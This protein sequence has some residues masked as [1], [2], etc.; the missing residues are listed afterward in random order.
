MTEGLLE[1]LAPYLP[2]LVLERHASRAVPLAA[3]SEEQFPSAVVLVDVSGFTRLA[4]RL[5]QVGPEGA[6]QLTRILNA[7]FGPLID[8]IHEHGGDVA[9]F[10]GDA[11][12]VLW[13]ALDGNLEDAALAGV[14]CALALQTVMADLAERGTTGG[15]DPLAIKVVVGAGDMRLAH[16]GGT[17]NRWEVM[18]TGLPLVQIGQVSHDARPGKVLLTPD[19][20]ALVGDR[21]ELTPERFVN[22]VRGRTS[23]GAPD[24][25]NGAARQ[26]SAGQDAGKEGSRRDARALSGRPRGAEVATAEVDLAGT[27]AWLRGY[28]PEAV[29]AR[30]EA[31]QSGWLSELRRVTVMF[32]NFPNATHETTLERAQSVM[33]RIQGVL[34]RFEGTLNKLSVDEKGVS[35]VA[36]FGLPPLSH[37]DD[38]A[39]AIQAA[40]TLRAALRQH[41]V[42]HAI[43]I[44]TGRAFCG[45]VGNDRRREYTV[46]GDIVNL[47]ARLMQAARQDILC[48][49]A[50][51]SLA[52][53]RFAYEHLAPLTLKGKA[54]PVP[55]VRPSPARTGQTAITGSL[56]A[57]VKAP[58]KA[59][60]GAAG[61]GAR[62][63]ATTGVVA[64][65]KA[66]GLD[67]HTGG[68]AS[69][70]GAVGAAAGETGV[71]AGDA[72]GDMVGR[73]AERL[74]LA[75]RLQ[76]LQSGGDPGVV[77]I[78]GEAG[79]GKSRL[80][81]ALAGLAA[82][83]GVRLIVG[84]G[85]AVERNT[86][87]HAWRGPL[88][89]LLDYDAAPDDPAGRCDYLLARLADDP[90]ALP[91]APLLGP[92]L[93]LDIPDN[94][95]T[96]QMAGG[97]RADNTRD[98]LLHLIRRRMAGRPVA[99][100]VEDAHWLDSASWALLFE[101]HRQLPG[102]LLVLALRPLSEPVPLEY[103]R[104]AAAESTARIELGSLSADESLAL[105]CQ[106]LGVRHLPE[107]VAR[108]IRERAGGHPF[109][110][111]ELAFALRDAGQIQISGGECRL[112]PGAALEALDLPGTVQGAIT[113]RVDRLPQS[114]QL[115][116]KVASVIGRVFSLGTLRDVHPIDADRS[117]LHDHL[118][119]LH[120]MDLTPLETPE[121][122]PTY[123][124][125]HV[126]TQQVVYD[127]M[128]FS[129]RQAMHRAV[130]EWYERE[131]LADLSAYYPLLA[132]HWGKAG[133][134]ART[135]I[136]L[137]RAGELALQSG[138]YR[139]AVE[140][141]TD[142]TAL[143]ARVPEWA[144]SPAASPD[145]SREA[146]RAAESAQAAGG[147]RRRAVAGESPDLAQDPPAGEF[148]SQA[149]AGADA[150]SPALRKARRRRLLGDAYLSLGRLAESRECLQQAAAILGFPVPARRRE[151]LRW[152]LTHA[153]WQVRNH[154]LQGKAAGR[155]MGR[156]R[157]ELL[158]A[159]RAF[160]RL[161]PVYFW[162]ND[163]L[164]TMFSAL[165]GLNLSEWAGPS[166]E[167]ARSYANLA[168]GVSLIP[169]H[170][171]AASYA[172]RAV[173][174]AGRQSQLSAKGWVQ[175]V[176]GLYLA[177]VG[178]LDKAREAIAAG[179]EIFEK[180]GDRRRHEECLTI[181]AHLAFASGEADRALRIYG[182]L[183]RSARE[184]G[185]GH[186]AGG[187]LTS[188]GFVLLRLGK[189]A[190]AAEAIREGLG[191][192]EESRAIT[193]KIGG[194]ALLGLA[195]LLS[196]DPTGA[197]EQV[198]FAL[199]RMERFRPTAVYTLEGYS[200][201]AEVFLSLWEA[202][203]RSAD[204]LLVRQARSAVA[205]QRLLA[206]IFPVAVPR[207]LYWQ[208][209]A[210]WLKGDRHG[211]ARLWRRGH[212][213]AARLGL[214]NDI[215]LL[216]S[217]LGALITGSRA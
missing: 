132:Y 205:Q 139:E 117:A 45:V 92:V 167:L 97:V 203:G 189:P 60:G 54:E 29:T 53:P 191:L 196:G 194:H 90:E 79:I 109:F 16:L 84:A 171:L 50:T 159:S 107:E 121:P 174:A 51:A 188:V 83:R 13:P 186:M 73:H 4:E 212:A 209:L 111:E 31:R 127:L 38:A 86:P 211:A 103:R 184:R 75:E 26:G 164:K 89:A 146:D 28:V 9:K 19:L 36:V 77:L 144:A 96:S 11:L 30:L 108:L 34:D 147:H 120:R 116:L 24:G 64:S 197:R 128:L 41:E 207:F 173:D 80:V 206:K 87:Y 46:M 204:G 214:P 133:D 138:A 210:A 195:L 125:K 43:G 115:T 216:E 93:G 78:E 190:E 154:F 135:L 192:L 156:P 58:D 68:K 185:D 70:A 101:V 157:E 104:L 14:E 118:A 183:V 94:P 124:F 102:I 137:D 187:S 169:L 200:A 122:E 198:T 193:E 150:G 55:V 145:A 160:E 76:A 12:L 20:A 131:H 161:G 18:V 213:Q 2:R 134:P 178:P 74:L 66:A 149:L 25:G 59:D 136:Y 27:E 152:G 72:S 35:M 6:E 42:V 130:A 140:F 175:E 95:T 39:R 172:R 162:L 176:L 52:G 199:E 151:W 155:G 44:A 1:E 63:A 142:A 33:L 65:G 32:V 148:P 110:S 62:D 215:K 163:P 8:R 37:E 98:L 143:E 165:A 141:L 22:A 15:P 166:P 153:L 57:P 99:I 71:S 10:A 114:L 17:R 56:D 181:E 7:H 123:I 23:R 47:A 105:V 82:E 158:E 126:I 119:M 49:Q 113:S 3:A 5:S 106:R 67:A 201:V 21:V 85:D 202:A 81:R 100:V 69:G 180:L 179:L 177:G 40:L 112:A 170:G 208:G 91:L 168:V 217:R 61:G 129:Q 48:D 182:H 88:S